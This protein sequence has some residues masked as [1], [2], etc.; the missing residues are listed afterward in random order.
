M[1]SYLGLRAHFFCGDTRD[2]ERWHLA[3]CCAWGLKELD[4]SQQLNDK[5]KN[6]LTLRQNNNKN[7]GNMKYE[8]T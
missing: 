5:N 2:G 8:L 7:N 1:S 6:I 4:T 3:Y